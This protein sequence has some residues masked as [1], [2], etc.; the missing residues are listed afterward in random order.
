M[1]T[2]ISIFIAI[3]FNMVPGQLV[4]T[5]M[6]FGVTV[7]KGKSGNTLVM[8]SMVLSL[9]IKKYLEVRSCN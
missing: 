9:Y 4:L 7:T 2:V 6:C 8:T 5:F 3:N 1:V